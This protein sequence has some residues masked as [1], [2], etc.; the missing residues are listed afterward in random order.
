MQVRWT[1]GVAPSSLLLI[2]QITYNKIIPY[3]KFW[4]YET[5]KNP[6]KYCKKNFTLEVSQGVCM[7]LVDLKRR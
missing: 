7:L 5:L 6:K 4:Q 1:T 3:M 2:C